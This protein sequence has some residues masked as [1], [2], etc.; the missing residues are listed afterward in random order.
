MVATAW[1]IVALLV[2]AVQNV[3]N[4]ELLVSTSRT[5]PKKVAPH[6]AAVRVDARGKTVRARMIPPTPSFV[7]AHLAPLSSSLSH[8]AS[9]DR[10]V[11]RRRSNDAE[12]DAM[13]VAAAQ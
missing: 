8:N 10:P 6:F 3:K 4:A 7:F 1:K 13:Q 11:S 9:K 12:M 5:T 2:T